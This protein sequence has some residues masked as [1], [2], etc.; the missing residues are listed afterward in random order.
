MLLP[1]MPQDKIEPYC[2]REFFSARFYS[3]FERIFVVRGGPKTR[4]KTLGA[5]PQIE[6]P[7]KRL[8]KNR[9]A[10]GAQG[11]AAEIPQ[12]P[13]GA[14][15]WSGKPGFLPPG[16]KMRGDFLNLLTVRNWGE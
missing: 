9:K 4:P 12:A 3:G 14:R 7:G 10:R 2:P 16:Q 15:N 8:F 11:I 13:R 1:W 6:K 5:Y